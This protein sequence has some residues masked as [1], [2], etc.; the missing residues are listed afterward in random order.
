[1]LHEVDLWMRALALVGTLGIDLGDQVTITSIT[2]ANPPNVLAA[3]H[4]A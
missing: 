4:G 2:S 1:M 3:S